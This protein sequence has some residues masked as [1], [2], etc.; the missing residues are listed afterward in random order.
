MSEST[1]A[2]PDPEAVAHRREAHERERIARLAWTTVVGIFA[3][4]L[5]LF[6][7]FLLVGVR[8]E[9]PFYLILNFVA[10]ITGLS[11]VVVYRVYELPTILAELPRASEQQRRINLAAIE[12]IRAELLGR[13][14]RSLGLARTEAEGAGLDDD[15]LIR[16]LTGLKRP[17]WPKIGRRYLIGYVIV[18]TVIL[19]IIATYP[20]EQDGVS[21]IERA[22]GKPAIIDQRWSPL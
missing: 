22:Q 15:E 6:Y 11:N 19:T 4:S 14:L 8:V 18:A 3:L 13:S 1:S 20:T 9:D 16:R 10:T 2:K 12:P 21:L 7:V 17:D 5:L